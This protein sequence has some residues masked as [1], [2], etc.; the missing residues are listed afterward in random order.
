MEIKSMEKT[1]PTP[2]TTYKPSGPFRAKMKEN[3]RITPEKSRD[4]V[5][6]IVIDLS[7]SGINYLEGMSLGIIPPGTQENGKP[8]RPRLYSI[9]SSR[10][11]DDGLASTVSLTIKRV[12]VKDPESGE[13]VYGLASNYVCD[14]KEGEELSITGPTGRTFFLPEDDSVNLIMVAAGT[15]IAPFRAFIHH[16]FRERGSWK[17]KVRLF[18]GSRTG[19]ES[20]YMNDEN[21]DIGQYMDKETFQSFKA[22]SEVEHVF[23]QRRVEENQDEIWQMLMEGNFAFYICGLKGMEEG[24]Y[25]I[26]RA[27]AQ[28]EGKDWDELLERF[29]KEGRWN[30]EV[31]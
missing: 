11:G 18:H 28:K 30:V 21:N 2:G 5:H 7:G 14:L 13:T 29:H 19:M 10:K 3:V 22:L 9:S 20:L 26:L 27:R 25:T 1:I 23:V 15:G 17:G 6:H 31:Y 4:D 8:H 12:I 16:I 24:I